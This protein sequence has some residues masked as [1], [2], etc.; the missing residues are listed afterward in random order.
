MVI[1]MSMTGRV[2]D[3]VKAAD[4][5]KRFGR[6]NE[7]GSIVPSLLLAATLSL[8]MVS[9]VFAQSAPAD[10]LEVAPAKGSTAL[11]AIGASAA[12]GAESVGDAVGISV[13]RTFLVNSA[14]VVKDVVIGDP[15]IADVIVQDPHRI[16]LVGR[17][18]GATNVFLIGDNG[19]TMRQ[20]QVNVSLDLEPIKAVLRKY[21]PGAS[22]EV[23]KVGASIMLTG[24]VRSQK[25]AD[26]A[27]QLVTGYI[28][29]P[30]PV[31]TAISL[32]DPQKG[33]TIFPQGGAN[34]LT[35][36]AGTAAP[37]TQTT[38]NGGT[39]PA[40]MPI[41]NNL[42]VINDQM[43]LIQVKIAEMK[44]SVAK[45]LDG[46]AGLKNGAL[47]S[48]S[49]LTGSGSVAAGALSASDYG[50]SII[51]LSKIGFSGAALAY[52]ESQD[53]TQV[54]AEPSLTA[55]SGETATFKAGDEIPTLTTTNT[56]TTSVTAVTY[57]PV[58][59]QLSFLP[60]VLSNGQISLQTA[61]SYSFIDKTQ[62][63]SLGTTVTYAISNRSVQ[64]TVVL[65]SGGSIMIG[66]ELLNE[67]SQTLSGIP[68]LKDLPFWGAL[69]RSRDYSN[70]KT[71]LVILVKAMVVHPIQFSDAAAL[72]TDG[73]KPA[74][75]WDIYVT[76][77]LFQRYAHQNSGDFSVAGPVGYIME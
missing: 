16:Y 75:D 56:G 31:H 2:G 5:K 58:G 60:L 14:D 50:G 18:E 7:A 77:R 54:L 45:E 63:Y 40:N 62:P 55:I 10:G 1:G 39:I 29:A 17:S 65:P 13:G 28:N 27:V 24:W 38:T 19:Q 8:G 76:G 43:V 33:Q 6:A 72:P 23:Q 32:G 71:E 51:N 26:A 64:S 49:S 22:I 42:R 4:G 36:T 15:G 48:V 46:A 53:L 34:A 41:I 66:G 37:S 52:L 59:V 21:M 47:T 11:K 68:F 74:S 67:D 73:L 44:R 69:F 25:D 70:G 30:P 9:P 12:D 61:T 20:I 57:Q 3:A 35:S